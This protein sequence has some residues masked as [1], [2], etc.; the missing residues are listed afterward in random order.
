MTFRQINQAS[1]TSNAKEQKI[2][3]EFRRR[4][5]WM[6]RNDA[7]LEDIRKTITILI[8]TI[9]SKDIIYTQLDR[10][11]HISKDLY[12]VRKEISTQQLTGREDEAF[13]F[14][15]VRRMRIVFLRRLWTH[16]SNISI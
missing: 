13:F 5:M 15:Q 6:K 7:D 4:V 9:E 16:H 1:N 8:E 10:D 11:S 2:C 3:S 12:D 14:T